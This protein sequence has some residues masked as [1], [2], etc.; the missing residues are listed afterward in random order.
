[1]PLSGPWPGASVIPNRS[2]R[3]SRSCAPSIGSGTRTVVTTAERSSSGEKSS[4]PIALMPSRQARPSRTCSLEGRFEPALEDHPERDVEADDDRD[5]GREGGVELLLGLRASA[6]SRGRSAERRRPS[7]ASQAASETETIARPG[8]AISAFCEPETTESSPHSSVS[9]G[10]APRL[11]IASTPTSAPA[12]FAAAASARTSATTPVEVSDC[13]TSTALAPPS[14]A[15]RAARSSADG[16]LAPLVADVVDLAAVGLG[17]LGPALAEVAG[18]DDDDAVA[19][20]GQVR[21][22]RLEA[23]RSRGRVE[24]DVAVGAEDLLQPLEALLVGRLEVRAAVMDDRQRHRGEHLR[25]HRRRPRGHQIALL[26][27]VTEPSSAGRPCRPLRLSSWRRFLRSRRRFSRS[28]WRPCSRRAGAIGGGP[29]LAAWSAA[30][31]AYA[32]ASAALAWGA[33]AG[34]DA[35]AFRVYYLFGGLLTAPLLGLGSLLLYGWRR[36]VGP[37]L[38]YVG[39]AVGIAIAVPVHGAFGGDI[40]GGAGPPRFLP[41][42]FARSRCERRRHAGRR[43]C[44][45]RSR[46]G[47]GRSATRSSSAGVAVAAAGTALSGLG[48]AK[49]AVFVAIAALLLYGGFTASAPDGPNQSL[50]SRSYTVDI[51]PRGP[52]RARSDDCGTVRPR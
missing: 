48:A 24:E 8:G 17:D 33:A 36:I 11:E 45:T 18:G 4:R 43:R 47:A 20:R 49:T 1:M 7:R 2:R 44:G 39:L 31:L 37:A 42:R 52:P 23:G 35:R 12:S 21:D 38:V 27:Q 5:G 22:D 26:G 6:P 28:G 13:V 19:R 9:Q 40:P 50:P 30:L 51:D 46:S 10:I 15:S 25:R 41:A 29:E 34:W 16:R 14:S 3:S 32:V